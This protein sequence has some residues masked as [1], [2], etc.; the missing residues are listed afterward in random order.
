MIEL[1]EVSGKVKDLIRTMIDVDPKKRPSM[2]QV[3]STIESLLPA[4]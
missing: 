1:P 2:E 4:E 3:K